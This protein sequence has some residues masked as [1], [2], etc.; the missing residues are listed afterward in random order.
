M[1]SHSP[2]DQQ[3]N[4]AFYDPELHWCKS[5]NVF[6][7]TAK[8]YLQHLHS[9]EHT[10]VVKKSSE[11]PWHENN[12]NVVSERLCFTFCAYFDGC[13]NNSL[14]L[15]RECPL[16]LEHPRVEHLFEVCSSLCPPRPGTASSAPFGWETCTALLCI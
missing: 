7:K 5:C 8:D 4:Y 16:T 6:P 12:P 11:S 13:N 9:K 2:L 15:P 14:R 3:I 1:N 10:E